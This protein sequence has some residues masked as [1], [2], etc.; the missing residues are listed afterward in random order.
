MAEGVVEVECRTVVSRR[1][2]REYDFGNNPSRSL[3]HGQLP[4]QKNQLEEPAG[5]VTELLDGNLQAIENRSVEV[6]QWC[7]AFCRKVLARWKR[8]TASAP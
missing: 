4:L 7:V 5:A 1:A 3:D 2:D 6:A 8:A